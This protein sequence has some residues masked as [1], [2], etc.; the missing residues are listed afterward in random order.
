M[1][2]SGMEA[3]RRRLATHDESARDGGYS[4]IEM[5]VVVGI[6][7]LILAMAMGM[8]ITITKL[9]GQNGARINQS[10]QGKVATESMTKALRTA[11]LPKQLSATCSGCDVAAFING[12]VRSVS[13]YANL[14]NDYTVSMSP[15]TITTNG[16]SKVTYTVAANGELSEVIRRPDPHRADD[17]NYQYTCTAGSSGCK[18]SNRVI[19]RDVSTTRTL[20]TYYDRN[21]AV[22]TPPLAGDALASVNS[23][24][25]TLSVQSA[26]N[27]Q[28]S[29]IVTRVTLPNAGVVPETTATATP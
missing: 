15:S 3:L 13:F 22:L 18:V 28:A 29:D 19:A 27:V 26:P 21:G 16:P 5:M 23:V 9:Q 2:G 4:L 14:N 1:K 7:S 20:F 24:D 10:Q 8:L 6:L 25:I 17:F 11:V 12:N